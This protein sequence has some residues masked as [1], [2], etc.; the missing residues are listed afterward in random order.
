M[1]LEKALVG[2]N[3]SWAS[4]APCLTQALLKG[5]QMRKDFRR[6]RL[7]ALCPSPDSPSISVQRKLALEWKRVSQKHRA[8]KSSP[9][10]EVRELLLRRVADRNGQQEAK[11]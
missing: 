2:S 8:S 5:K 3:E 1:K 11:N 4:Q 10:C 6:C 9:Q 7:L